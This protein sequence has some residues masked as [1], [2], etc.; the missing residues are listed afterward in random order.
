LEG[1]PAVGKFSMPLG[2]V[3]CH[4]VPWD[5]CFCSTPETNGILPT[6]EAFQK[7]CGWLQ[8]G[9]F[10]ALRLKKGGIQ[11]LSAAPGKHMLVF[12]Q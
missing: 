11:T 8:S 7:V 9:L 10:G 5:A 3:R 12:T 1:A 6:K 2:D 4:P